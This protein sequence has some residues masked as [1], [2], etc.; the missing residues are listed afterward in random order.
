MN[1]DVEGEII[2]MNSEDK[3]EK[4]EGVTVTYRNV[5][6]RIKE[7]MSEEMERGDK[8]STRQMAQKVGKKKRRV[9]TALKRLRERG[10]VKIPDAWKRGK[11]W[12]VNVE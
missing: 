2:K 11:R 9:Y 6:E 4:D 8:F 5:Y 1:G 10:K 7:Y 12:K 3:K